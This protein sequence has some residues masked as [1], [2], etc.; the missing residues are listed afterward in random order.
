MTHH[1]EKMIQRRQID[2][3]SIKMRDAIVA[4]ADR[5]PSMWALNDPGIAAKAQ[6]Q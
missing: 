1:I 6:V 3:A 5:G 2:R 4:K